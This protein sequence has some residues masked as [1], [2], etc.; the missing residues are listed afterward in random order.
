MLGAAK[1]KHSDASSDQ[2]PLFNTQIEEQ[3]KKAIELFEKEFTDKVIVLYKGNETKLKNY[4]IP[5]EG[6]S[7]ESVFSAVASRVL[8][9]HFTEKNPD[10]PAFKDLLTPNAKGNFDGRIKSALRKLVYFN[11][12]NRDGEAILSG[13]GLLGNQM[14]DTQNS[15]YADALRKKIKARGEGKVLNKDDILY[16]HYLPGNLWYSVDYNL[17]YQLEFIV[18]AALVYKG[19]IEVNWSGKKLTATNFDQQVLNLDTTDYC[20]FQTVQQPVGINIKA[21]KTLFSLLNLADLSSELDKP[22]T[23]SKIISVCSERVKR[24][25]T[26][27]AQIA[28][29]IK[30]RNVDLLSTEKTL[31]YL[32]KLDR[33]AQMLDSIQSFN[34]YGKLRGFSHSEDELCEAF[35]A[36]PLCDEIEKLVTRAS[37]FESLIAYLSQAQSYVVESERPL[38]DDMEQEIKRLGEVLQ[39]GNDADYKKYETKLNSL[40]DSYAEYYLSQYLKCRLSHADSLKKE[41][42]LSSEPKRICDTIK[43]VD[44]LNKTEYE[45]WLNRIVSLKEAKQDVT[46]ASIK[47]EPYHDFNPREFYDKPTYS[48]QDL[49]SQLDEILAKWT[50]AMRSIFRDPSVQANIDMLN[51]DSRAIVSG[52]KEGT[53]KLTS[54]NAGRIRTYIA[55]LS[56]GF[57]RIE[58]DPKDFLQ[59][60]SK[61]MTIE[62]TRDAFN[63]YLDGLCKGRERT[64]IRIVLSE[65]K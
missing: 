11:Q 53:E 19:D 47:A 29:G 64:K 7:K 54:V 37:K 36:W 4:Q 39:T 3:T 59:V 30:C 56:K 20:T 55:E 28:N 35:E 25:V 46:K 13:L 15:R 27:K 22:E 21:L 34:T 63:G 60:F 40:I 16:P 61:P 26:L 41:Q 10:Y 14:I 58:L 9:N 23:L 65:K 18:L 48:I 32:A 52:F 8:N 50:T 12:P 62:E 49:S 44:I 45:N 43:D 24:A 6:S 57:D 33:F 42:I 2:K 5:G 17:E 51:E 31:E 38:Y 1:A